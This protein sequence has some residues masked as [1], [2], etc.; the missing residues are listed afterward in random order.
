MAH[1][2]LQHFSL[3]MEVGE[4]GGSKKY[5]Y[6]EVVASISDTT[7]AQED[8]HTGNNDMIE[9]LS[10]GFRIFELLK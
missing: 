5:D 9:Y 10:K 2:F 8:W 1:D 3:P 7:L 6:R 4:L